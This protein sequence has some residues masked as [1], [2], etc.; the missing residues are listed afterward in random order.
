[1]RSTWF[2]FGW[3]VLALPMAGCAGPMENHQAPAL[4]NA[5]VFVI[6]HAEKP[7]DGDGLTA[8]GELRANRYTN[9]FNQI[10]I[11]GKTMRIDHVF[12]AAD[13]RESHRPRLTVE[14]TARMLGL[15][16]DT[17]FKN[18]AFQK[19][20]DEVRSGADGKAILVAWHHGEI[21]SLL[22]ALGAQPAQLLPKGKWPDAVFDWVI[23]LRYDE[24]GKVDAQRFSMDF[25]PTAPG[26]PASATPDAK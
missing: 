14:P 15:A 24:D 16:V 20:A 4:T 3:V 21:P 22:Q 18:K 10:A 26:K 17:R 12:A 8:A 23:I 5:I 1:M 9:F 2:V 6:R 25:M 11:N 7:D 13:S 19:L